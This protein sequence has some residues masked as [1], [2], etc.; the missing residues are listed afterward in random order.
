MNEEDSP[1]SQ[2]SDTSFIKKHWV[3]ITSILGACFLLILNAPTLITNL[4]NLPRDVSRVTD[5]F[6]GWYYEDE[7][8]TGFWSEFPEGYANLEEMNLGSAKLGIDITST[9]GEIG[10][11]IGTREICN[12]LPFGEFLHIAGTVSGNEAVIT[13][14]DYIGGKRQKFASLTL[15]RDGIIMTVKSIG[16]IV[17]LFP[18][19]AKIGRHPDN[20]PLITEFGH[21]D[22]HSDISAR[23][24]ANLCEEKRKAYRERLKKNNSKERRPIDELQSPFVSEEESK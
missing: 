9:N 17:D 2:K 20:Y 7:V 14:F 16:G 13:A 23:Y 5:K 4:E 8:W 15:R 22:E 1:S 21:P 19:D 3:G 12:T 6:L 24:F 18:Q 11:M 10:G